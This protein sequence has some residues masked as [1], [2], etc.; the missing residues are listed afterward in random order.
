MLELLMKP[1]RAERKPW[2]MFF[3]GAL[4]ASLSI[5]IVDWIF[6]RDSVLSQYVSILIITFT[7]MFSIPFFYFII[8]F[9]E[10]KDMEIG[11]ERILIK[12]HGKAIA[13]LIYLFIGFIIAFAF[14]YMILPKDVTAQN[15]KAQIQQYCVINYASNFAACIATH[16]ITDIIVGN[17]VSVTGNMP[18]LMNHF[19]NI[20]INNIY[21]LIFTLIFSLTFG[22]GAIFILAWNAS[23]IAAA[24]GIFTESSFQNIHLGLMRYMIHGIPEIAAYFIAALAGGILSTAIIR[25]ECRKDKLWCVLQDSVDLIIVAIIVLV[26]SAFIEVFITPALF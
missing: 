11:E 8:R 21:V 20:L 24:I 18:A 23:V 17:A 1:G 6:M 15:F 19:F 7:V 9:E 13:S 2:E 3:I 16:G 4:Y 25:N 22:A 5:L 12:E 26:I 10:K 14:W